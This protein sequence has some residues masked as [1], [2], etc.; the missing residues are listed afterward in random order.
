MSAGPLEPGVAA[1]P[2]ASPFAR[3]RARDLI[4]LTIVLGLALI[5]LLAIVTRG[6]R[7]RPGPQLLAVLLTAAIGLPLPL[8]A[9]RAG[10]RWRRLFGPRPSRA[11]LLMAMVV[12]PVA[13]FTLADALLLYVPLSYLAPGF[14]KRQLLDNTMFDIHTLRQWA[15]LMLAGVGLAP[16]LEEIV[17][18]GILMQR[19]SHRWG[20]R[21]GVIA[22]SALFAVMHGEWLG[23]FLFGVAMSALYLR[24]RKLWVP[25]AA[26]ALNNFVFF[27][28]TLYDVLMHRPQAPDTLQEF[29]EG[30][31]MGFPMLAAGVVGLWAYRRFVWGDTSVRALLAGP[32]P[33]DAAPSSR[34]SVP[35]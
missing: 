17:F 7:E 3:L 22:S 20:T 4:G 30:F 14:V 35:L 13:L 21:T 32:V 2:D 26:H 28:P 12:A 10:L 16:V 19:W 27:A 11:E 5:V 31:V 24:T 9:R 34:P 18:R 33:Y 23:H 29:R 15:L 6:W 1:P 25:I 8:L